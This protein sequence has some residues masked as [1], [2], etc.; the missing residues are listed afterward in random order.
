MAYFELTDAP[1]LFTT[2][3]ADSMEICALDVPF[4]A[5]TAQE[6]SDKAVNLVRACEAGQLLPR[7]ATDETWFE[8][9]FCD[10]RQR[11]WSSQEI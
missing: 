2:L 6:L 9:K 11:C 10:W 3:N 4:D 1:A 8:C 5:A 7:C